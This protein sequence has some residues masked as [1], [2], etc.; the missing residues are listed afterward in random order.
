MV[1]IWYYQFQDA[2]ITLRFYFKFFSARAGFFRRKFLRKCSIKLQNKQHQVSQGH[3]AMKTDRKSVLDSEN[4]T[5]N[6]HG[7]LYEP[8]CPFISLFLKCTLLPLILSHIF[9]LEAKLKKLYK[10]FM[11]YHSI[12]FLAAS[13]SYSVVSQAAFPQL[14]S[15]ISWGVRPRVGMAVDFQ[16]GWIL[17][18]EV[19]VFSQVWFCKH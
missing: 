1:I 15:F 6:D 13:A 10:I 18:N 11:I 16:K 4:P 9:H 8:G 14:R 7:A 17:G 5:T 3:D 2:G 12:E 19:T